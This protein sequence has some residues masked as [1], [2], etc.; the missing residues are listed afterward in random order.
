LDVIEQGL[1]TDDVCSIAEGLEELMRSD[2]DDPPVSHAIVDGWGNFAKT[3]LPSVGGNERAQAHVAFYFGAM[4]VLQ[5][6]QQVIADR[7]DEE[8]SLASGMLEADLDEF[9]KSHAFA[10][11]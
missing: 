8:V 5:I 6:A 9:I 2:I 10:V 3:V 7:S 11:Q 1:T 4:Y